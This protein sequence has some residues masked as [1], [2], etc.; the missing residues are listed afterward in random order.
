MAP[1]EVLAEQHF[2]SIRPLLAGIEVPDGREGTLFGA[3]PLTVELL[4]NRVTGKERQRILAAL[5]DGVGRPRSSAR[6]R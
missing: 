5:A 3:R 2:A 4:T 6:T 1:T